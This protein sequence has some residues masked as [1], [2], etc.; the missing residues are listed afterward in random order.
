MILQWSQNLCMT[1]P[2]DD[3]M[4]G[5]GFWDPDSWYSGNNLFVCLIE[6][7]LTTKE[8]FWPPEACLQGFLK[9]SFLTSYSNPFLSEKPACLLLGL[10]S[11]LIAKTSYVHFCLWLN[12]ILKDWAGRTWQLNYKCFC[13]PVSRIAIMLLFLKVNSYLTTLPFF[14]KWLIWLH[15]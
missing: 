1:Q 13:M 12:L 7:H 11:H 6:E 3:G 5:K 14:S 10:K 15:C 2:F 8:V 4:I 9:F